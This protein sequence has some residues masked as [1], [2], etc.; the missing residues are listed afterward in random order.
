MKKPLIIATL[1][2]L[3]LMSGAL[4]AQTT[5]GD[6]GAPSTTVPAP[7][8]PIPPAG[9]QAVPPNSPAIPPGR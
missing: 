5:G 2:A 7:P 9:P 4:T 8:Q 1:S 6:A 3:A